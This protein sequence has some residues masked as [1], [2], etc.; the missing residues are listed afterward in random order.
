M[1]YG[2]CPEEVVTD[3]WSFELFYMSVSLKNVQ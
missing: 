1:S 3:F 2:L